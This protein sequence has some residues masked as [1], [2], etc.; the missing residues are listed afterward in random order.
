MRKQPTGGKMG[1]EQKQAGNENPNNVNDKIEDKLEIAGKEVTITL[2]KGEAKITLPSDV[3]PEWKEK[4]DKEFSEKYSPAAIANKRN[5]ERNQETRLIL[6]EK[7]NEIAELKQKLESYE[8]GKTIDER[9]RKKLKLDENDEI[10][11]DSPEYREAFHQ[12][13]VEDARNSTQSNPKKSALEL[14]IEAE[15]FKPEEVAKAISEE[16]GTEMNPKTYAAWKKINSKGTSKGEDFVS[17]LKGKEYKSVTILEN[18]PQ[19]TA[20]TRRKNANEMI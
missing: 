2:E 19:G 10:P 7:D 14:Q 12:I 16:F 6:T 3:T 11:I 13:A 17:R 4:F 18:S 20:F 8:K 1:D 5:F 9:L 15:G